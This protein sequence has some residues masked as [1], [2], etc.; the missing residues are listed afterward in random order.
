VDSHRDQLRQSVRLLLACRQGAAVTDA[1]WDM[2]AAEAALFAE[3]VGGMR[4]LLRP[5]DRPESLGPAIHCP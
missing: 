1:E 2:A 5:Q 4:A 3:A